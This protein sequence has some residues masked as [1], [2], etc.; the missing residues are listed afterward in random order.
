MSFTAAELAE[1]LQGEVVGD[2]SVELIGLAPADRA[3]AGEL[4]FA[5]NAAYFAAADQSQ[6]AAI[7][8]AGAFESSSKVLIRAANARWALARALPVFFPPAQHPRAIQRTPVLAVS[9]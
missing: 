7:L 8:V 9:A 4:T 5:E 1:K 3:R 6:A 2:G